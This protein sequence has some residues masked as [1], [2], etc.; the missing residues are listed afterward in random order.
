MADR[1][2]DLFQQRVAKVGRL[3]AQGIDPYPARLHRTHTVADAL[4]YFHG[5][6][7]SGR[8][9]R[10][11]VAVAG[12]VMALRGMGRVTFA[13]VRDGTGSVQLFI[14]PADLPVEQ[15]T[16]LAELDTGD[17]IAAE[18]PMFRTRTER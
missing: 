17:S 7:A 12:R 5:V 2:E 9:P 11:I 16:V 1:G 10:K 13:D 3:R 18:G 8:T 14:R 4:G 15:Q 6:E